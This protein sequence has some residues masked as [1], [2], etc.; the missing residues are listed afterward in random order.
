MFVNSDMKSKAITFW[1]LSV[2]SLVIL[3]IVVGGLTRL[4]DSGLSI[5]QWELFK[6]I[7]PPISQDDWNIYFDKYKK[8]PE[9]IYLNSNITLSEFKIIFYWEYFHRL[10]GRIIGLVAIIPL[11][12]FFYKFRNQNVSLL[13]YF[14]IF[15]LI[16][17][18]G[19]L[20]WYM[21]ESGLVDRVDVSHYRLAL[22]LLVAFV[23]L[24]L[25][26]WYFLESINVKPFVNK[27]PNL[28]LFFLLLLILIQILLGAFLAGLDGGLIYN[29][30]PDM[31]GNF[32]PND[33][34]V[35]RFFTLEAFNTPSILQFIHRNVAYVLCAFI[36]YLN[37]IYILKKLP[38][39]P[40][41]ILDL[42]IIFQITLGIITL[43]SGVKITY[44]SLHQIG[45]IF[46]IS[47]FLY[48]YY[49][50]IKINLLPSN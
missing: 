7:L 32:L 6:G 4:T 1:L 34:D 31:N 21:V 37:I 16:C 39:A 17:L 42:T 20:G 36:V 23:I 45:S 11:L 9:F 27:L 3:M 28:F 35:F 13:K 29:T 18:Q 26:Y 47:S 8:I 22:H 48:I 5:T 24:S 46:L 38:L 2:Y 40:L 15:I 50:N 14:S 44:A 25:T 30:W 41:L 43:I 49:R 10:L 12:Y 33:T 19:F